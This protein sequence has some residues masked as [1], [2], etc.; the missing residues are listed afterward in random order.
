MVLL[1]PKRYPE[2]RFTNLPES[3]A[4]PLQRLPTCWSAL[5]ISFHLLQNCWAMLYLQQ[6]AMLR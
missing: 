4:L 6:A 2:V 5:P 1:A 3:E